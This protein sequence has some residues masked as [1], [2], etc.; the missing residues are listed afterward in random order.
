MNPH[1][2]RI[3]GDY[4]RQFGQGSVAEAARSLKLLNAIKVTCGAL[5]AQTDSL[6]SQA[7]GVHSVID[8]INKQRLD[9]R[10]GDDATVDA[11]RRAQ[12]FVERLLDRLESR[13]EIAKRDPQL[14]EDDGVIE[15]F[16]AAIDAARDFHNALS[17]LIF[18]I[19]E[20]DADISER[21]AVH[22]SA[23]DLIAE[24]NR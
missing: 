3:D 21:G 7:A 10:L 23:D 13:R 11:F 4:V 12:G 14:N 17:E 8:E 2:I 18:A 9:G 6:I 5:R 16:D 15:A 1:A 19:L 22:D 24:L 20:N